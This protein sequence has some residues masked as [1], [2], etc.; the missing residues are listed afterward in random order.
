VV[1]D[2]HQRG[3]VLTATVT[4]QS[5]QYGEIRAT[6]TGRVNKDGKVTGRL[7]HTKAPANWKSQSRDAQVSADGRTISGK[8]SF[9]GGGGQNFVWTKL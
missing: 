3:Q 9:D 7:Q 2:V 4:Y 5:N 6:F 1:F 8:T